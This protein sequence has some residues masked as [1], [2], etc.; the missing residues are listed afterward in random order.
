MMIVRCPECSARFKAPE[1]MAGQTVRCAKCKAAFMVPKLDEPEEIEEVQEAPRSR[2]PARDD[3]ARPARRRAQAVMEDEDEE[4]DDAEE[5]EVEVPRPKRGAWKGVRYGVNLIIMAYW[6][7]I[8]GG[9]VMVVLTLL[10]GLLGVGVPAMRPVLGYVLFAVW[11]FS[12]ISLIVG[13]FMQVIG[14]GYAMA[15]PKGTGTAAREQA[16]AVFALV[17]SCIALPFVAAIFASISDTLGMVVNGIYLL[18]LIGF[19][20]LF[21]LSL[22]TLSQAM[23]ER[24]LAAK[25]IPYFVAL[26]VVSGITVLIW[27]AFL[28]ASGMTFYNDMAIVASV[29]ILFALFLMLLGPL[30]LA[31]WLLMLLQ[32]VR[33]ALDST[34]RNK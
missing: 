20:I 9:G 14:H 21:P 29:T 18:A 23:K 7:I 33:D 15:V 16:I 2:R 3:D 22:R 34:I 6:T 28:R 10:L 8:I 12:G 32:Q 17:C 24:K 26:G 30:V 27:F 11:A 19:V 13:G 25:F 31:I 4:F 5:E 1:N